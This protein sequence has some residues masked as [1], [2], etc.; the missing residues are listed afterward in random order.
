MP[1][2]KEKR[3]TILTAVLVAALFLTDCAVKAEKKPVPSPQASVPGETLSSSLVHTPAPSPTPSPVVPSPVP[4]PSASPLPEPADDEMVRVTDY[5]DGIFVE[6]KYATQDNFTGQVIYDFTD[7]RLRYG[8]VKKLA[9]VQDE[10]EEQG[11]SLKIWDAFR[12]VSAQFKLWEVCPNSAYVANPNTG[13]SSHSTGNTVDITLVASDGE[14]VEMPT[15][16]D[17]FTAAADR[18]YSDV[19]QTAAENALLLQSA[20]E[21][22]GFVGYFSEWWHFSDCVGYPVYEQ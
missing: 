22:Q 5:I 14:A 6:L 7:A 8:T 21:A 15:G 9:A 10:L 16:F 18:D 11:L 17:D 4:S 3:L 1:G 13:Y 12:P 19:N 20:M 2:K